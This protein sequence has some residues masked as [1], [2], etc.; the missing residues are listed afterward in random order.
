MQALDAIVGVVNKRF[1]QSLYKKRRGPKGYGLVRIIR[2]L[3]FAKAKNV[4][5]TRTM[6]KYLKKHPDELRKLGFKKVPSRRSISD[7]KKNHAL[8]LEKTVTLL[9][10]KY[11]M[12]RSP[13]FTLVDSAPLPDSKDPE[14]KSGKTGR[15]WFKGFKVHHCCDDQ[16]VPLK[17]KV[18]TGNV[19]DSKPAKELFVKSP[20]TLADAA[21]D[22]KELKEE[23]LDRGT[24]LI[25]DQNPR[26]GKKK[27]KRP[28][29]LKKL[30]YLIEQSNSI[31]K[32]PIM[33]NAWQQVK[34][35][36]RKT[37]Y[38]L[39]S[40]ILIQAIAI[41]TLMKTGEVNLK[42]SEVLL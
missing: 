4:Y 24:L 13:K 22:S 36:L 29:I 32:G 27:D 11:A 38:A 35:L 33:Q 23:A 34:G 21:Y 37:T 25:A 31:M 18:T 39:A 5:K 3:V 8:M 15:G 16:R 26:R 17:A 40:I 30:R 14:A 20:V 6:V 12:M 41:Y 9:G 19:H 7:W 2:L 28:V 42:V 1:L 10:G